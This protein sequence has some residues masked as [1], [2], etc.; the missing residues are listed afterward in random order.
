MNVKQ[1]H[2]AHCLSTRHHEIDRFKRCNRESYTEKK[3][4]RVFVCLPILIAASAT[5]RIRLP[6]LDYVWL[7]NGAKKF[8]WIHISRC[9]LW[10][11]D[12]LWTVGGEKLSHLILKIGIIDVSVHLHYPKSPPT[13]LNQHHRTGRMETLPPLQSRSHPIL[14]WDYKMF[15]TFSWIKA[16]IK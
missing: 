2:W 14:W 16:Q 13:T 9:M 6:F 4:R 12:R 8:P 1:K 3:C 7:K 15:I 11:K 5:S 10:C